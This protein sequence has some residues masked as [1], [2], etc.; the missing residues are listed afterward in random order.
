MVVAITVR[1][2]DA[3]VTKQFHDMTELLKEQKRYNASVREVQT[4]QGKQAI[5]TVTTSTP[6]DSSSNNNNNLHAIKKH[7]STAAHFDIQ[8]AGAPETPATSTAS[9][10]TVDKVAL[11]VETNEHR[12]NRKKKKDNKDNKDKKDEVL[13]LSPHSELINEQVYDALEMHGSVDVF[14][15]ENKVEGSVLYWG[16]DM[17]DE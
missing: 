11:K 10:A 7:P 3:F 15:E 8:L 12:K 2:S 16:S 17:E 4:N 6:N 9:T 1:H 13:H 5:K 14:V